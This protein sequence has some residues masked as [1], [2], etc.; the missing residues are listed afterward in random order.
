[1][2]RH[3]GA[4]LAVVFGL[5]G[6]TGWSAVVHAQEPAQPA[7]T[8]LAMEPYTDV[9]DDAAYPN[10]L[11]GTLSVKGDLQEDTAIP[12]GWFRRTTALQPWFAWKAG[13]RERTG[14]SFGGSWM[15]LGQS[16]SSS[17]I[18]ENTSVG[19]KV[20]LNFSLDLF[21]RNE[22]NALSLDMAV[23]DRRPV[24]TDLAPLFAG[25]GA[26][27]LVPTA[28]T[29]GDF[30][31]GVTQFYLRQNLFDNR[32]QY[33]IGKIFAPN[34]IDAYPFFDDNRQFL[35][36]AFSTSPTIAS[37][38][39]GFGAVAAWYPTSGGLYLKPGMFTTH[40][41]D[42]GSTIDDFFNESEHFYMLEVG[43]SELARTGTPIQARAAMDANNIHLTG[44]YKD[45]EANGPPRAYGV[46]FNANFMYGPNLMWFVRAGWSDGWLVDR[47]AALGIGWRPTEHFSDLFGVAI[48]AS[49][50]VND[51]LR[52]QYSAEVFYRFH[53]T[54]NF[55]ITPDIQL[56]HRPSLNP[57]KDSLWV[58]SLRGRLTF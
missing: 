15:L 21:N 58:F 24:G 22:P 37:P 53:I 25:L 57:A 55:A 54:P 23:E 16:Y 12:T 38:L 1:M 36:Q 33:S 47:S 26:G 43:W 39:R 28:A 40:S 30:S 7:S 42:T 17:R 10:L 5:A 48:G 56:Q 45:A 31:L 27:S 52:N 8:E 6:M 51:V 41:D 32:F 19:S 50:P 13:V 34:F 46:A 3:G 44:W 29:Y 49:E 11:D 2:R 35:T 14:F 18:D 9:Y 20:T 4:R